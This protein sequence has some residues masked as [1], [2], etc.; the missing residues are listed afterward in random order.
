V[1]EILGSHGQVS[2]NVSVLYLMGYETDHCCSNP[3]C[4]GDMVSEM[5]N[6]EPLWP[7]VLFQAHG[8]HDTADGPEGLRRVWEEDFPDEIPTEEDWGASDFAFDR[9]LGP[10]KIVLDNHS[11]PVALRMGGH[12]KPQLFGELAK[13][14]LTRFDRRSFWFG[15]RPA[16]P[17]KAAEITAL[18]PERLWNEL[19]RKAW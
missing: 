9:E 10:L 6:A 3:H 17:E 13:I 5:D 11:H 15:A 14:S 12:A 2:R 4:D 19:Q 1:R 16:R 18:D 8:T 7:I